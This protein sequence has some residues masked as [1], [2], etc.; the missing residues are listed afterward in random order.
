MNSST[1]KAFRTLALLSSIGL[2]G[3]AQAHITLQ[4]QKAETGANYRAVLQVGHGCEGNSPTRQIIVDIPEG[5]MGARPMAKAGWKIEVDKAKLPQP[6]TI[7]GVTISD[8]VTQIRWTGG[9]LDDAVYDE[10]VVVAKLPD[11]TGPLYWKI[12]QVCD[13]GR[14]DWAEIPTAGK[15]LS[16]YRTP[17]AVMELLPKTSAEPKH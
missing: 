2:L 5:V 4:N 7:H 6:Y 15:K 12:S 3:N 11:R 10:F 16:D 17:A 8:Y 1:N 14:L 13:Q 9:S